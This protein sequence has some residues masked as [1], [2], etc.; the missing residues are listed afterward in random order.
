MKQLAAQAD[1]RWN[2]QERFADAP[3]SRTLGDGTGTETVPRDP[4]GYVGQTEPDS[5]EGV[6]QDVNRADLPLGDTEE[7]ARAEAGV[8]TKARRENP[9]EKNRKQNPSEGWQPEAWSPGPR[10][11]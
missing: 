4:G 9:W 11:R 5:V 3:K 7:T 10:K 1:A 6:R 8:A 2:S